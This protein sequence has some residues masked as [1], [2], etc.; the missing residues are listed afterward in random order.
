MNGKHPPLVV[1]RN[2]KKHFSLR[3]Q[4]LN[5]QRTVR[6]VDGVSFDIWRGE[7]LAV[8]GESG[9]GKSTLARCIVRLLEPTEGTIEFS[10]TDITHLGLRE[11]RAFRLEMQMI[12]QDPSASLNPHKTVAQIVEYGLKFMAVARLVN[13][14]NVSLRCCRRSVFLQSRRTGARE[15]CQAVSANESGSRGPSYSGLV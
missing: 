13:A 9:C 10:G 5:P 1:V 11:L 14:V 6:A 4:L 15:T 7:T 12:F 2:L 8:V 3:R